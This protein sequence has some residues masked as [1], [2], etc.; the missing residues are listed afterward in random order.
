MIRF[1]EDQTDYYSSHSISS[2]IHN[3]TIQFLAY[4]GNAKGKVTLFYILRGLNKWMIKTIVDEAIKEFN[5]TPE[6]MEEI[7]KLAMMG[8]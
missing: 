2:L 6:Q 4:L 1:N 5:I 8:V 7:T 3:K